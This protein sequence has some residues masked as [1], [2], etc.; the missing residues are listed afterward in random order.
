MFN[1]FVL[2]NQ[3]TKQKINFGQ[4]YSSEYFFKEG[5]VN[6]GSVD[7]QQNTYSYPYQVG[8]S[9]S[10]TTIRSRQVS[11]KGYITYIPSLTDIEEVNGEN[12]RLL[13]EIISKKIEKKKEILNALIVPNDYIKMYIGDYYIEGK[14]DGSI[15]YGKTIEENNE[16]FCSFLIELYCA[17]PMFRKI[18]ETVSNIA[19]SIGSF[20]FP[21][22]LKPTGIILSSRKSYQLISVENEGNATIGCVISIEAKSIVENLE[23]ENVTTGEKI[24]I[25]KT[26][27]AGEKIVINTNDGNEKGITG[28]IG[29]VTENYYR[30]W[31]QSN[32]WMKFPQ[33]LS[34][35][36]YS[37]ENES[38]KYVDIKIQMYPEKYNLEVE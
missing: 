7:V 20:H 19:T 5:G 26:L 25:N 23:I 38:E 3:T 30:Y 18:K 2:E 8:L 33:G 29:L 16:Y 34:L 4:D 35:I 22:I 36:G 15:Q 14:P 13:S 10:S 11:I 1:S 21:L 9:I 12:G 32:N 27:Q 28:T 31:D 24:K 17:N 37:T 6:I